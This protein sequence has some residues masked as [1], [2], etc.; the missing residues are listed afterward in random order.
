MG[1]F[2]VV[3]FSTKCYN[4]KR[5]LVSPIRDP[6]LGPHITYAQMWELFHYVQ[7]NRYC[8]GGRYK[9]EGR[10]WKEK[11]ARKYCQKIL[12]ICMKI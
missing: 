9:Q 3:F 11:V 5:M 10:G 4:Q 6:K 8:L 7:S 1:Y 12:Y 2:V